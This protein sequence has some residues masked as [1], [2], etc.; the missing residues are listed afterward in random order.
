MWFKNLSIFRIVPP[1]ETPAD[2]FLERLESQVFQSCQAGDA[3]RE[4]WT[5][6]LGV[7]GA[8]LLHVAQGFWCVC[9]RREEKVIPG[10]ALRERVAQ[11]LDATEARE[12]FRPGRKVRE[13]LKDEV[14]N[15]M[16]AVA[17]TQSRRTQAIIDPRSGWLLVDSASPGRSEDLVALLRRSLEGFPVRRLVTQESPSKVMTRWLAEEAFPPGVRPEAACEL[18]SPDVE[19]ATVKAARQDLSAPEMTHH[20]EVGKM[21]TRLALTYEDRLA[22]DLDDKLLLRRLRFLETEPADS[23]P[24]PEDHAAQFDADFVLMALELSRFIPI[25]TEWFGGEAATDTPKPL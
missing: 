19:G 1:F 17:F 8:P 7:E 6:P 11:R 10:G 2:L 24:D 16:L 25:L 13:A 9:L 23:G 4:G 20:L 14:L 18:K 5:P 22:F 12:G 3:F 15:E 21:V